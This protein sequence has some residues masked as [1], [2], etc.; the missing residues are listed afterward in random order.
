MQL[1]SEETRILTSG[2]LTFTLCCFFVFYV[3]FDTIHICLPLS[4]M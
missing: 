4:K 3:N 1:L 2:G